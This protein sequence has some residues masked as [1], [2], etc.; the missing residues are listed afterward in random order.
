MGSSEFFSRA[1]VFIKA[2][3]LIHKYKHEEDPHLILME[4]KVSKTK[5]EPH[6]QSLY[7]AIG[8]AYEDLKKFE[9]SFKF[10]KLANN[11]A[12]KKFNYNKVIFSKIIGV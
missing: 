12:D 1:I 9:K 8:K 7:F 6:L 11:I 5:S 2:I 10:L 3:S 4:N